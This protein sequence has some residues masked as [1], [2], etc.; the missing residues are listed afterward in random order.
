MALD[1][2][3]EIWHNPSASSRHSKNV[4]VKNVYVTGF[5]LSVEQVDGHS[6]TIANFFYKK[7]LKIIHDI[8]FLKK[9]FFSILSN[10]IQIRRHVRKCDHNLKFFSAAQVR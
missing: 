5:K 7:A 3:T 4:A 6:E 1:R 2:Y 10:S 8:L 9:I